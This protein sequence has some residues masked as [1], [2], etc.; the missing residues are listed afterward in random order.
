MW[1][2][3]LIISLIGT[4]SHFLYNIT[5]H[6]KIVGLFA[7]VNES[8]WEHIKIALTPSIL[9]SLYDGFIYGSNP[10]YF[11][12]KLVSLLLIIIIIPLIFYT[13]QLFTKKTILLVDILLF[14]VS[15]I[16]SRLSFNYILNLSNSSFI[17]QYISCVLLF[18]LF[19]CYLLLTLLPLELELFQDPNSYKYGFNGH[20]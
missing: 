13:Y 5:N 15:I 14:Y 8:T 17:C 9:Y 7:S 4:I 3:I 2:S 18:I 10:N 6:N 11:F 16:I 12:A 19:G 20:K 1:T